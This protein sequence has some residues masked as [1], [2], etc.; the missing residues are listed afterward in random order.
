LIG[1]FPLIEVG[2]RRIDLFIVGHVDLG[3]VCGRSTQLP[4]ALSE[5]IH[6]VIAKLITFPYPPQPDKQHSRS[7][8]CHH[9]LCILVSA[10]S[11]FFFAAGRVQQSDG[12]PHAQLIG[13]EALK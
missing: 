10:A 6:S 8:G 7:R 11:V 9:R 3:R 2:I 1:S 5:E 12:F 4:K 13:R